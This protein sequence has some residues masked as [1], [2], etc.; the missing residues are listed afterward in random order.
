MPL[1]N[2]L[3]TIKRDKIESADAAHGLSGHI[4]WDGGCTCPGDFAKAY[5]G[6]ADF[7]MSGGLFSGHE[8]SG[9]ELIE[10]DYLYAIKDG[11][12]FQPIYKGKRPDLDETAAVISQLKYKKD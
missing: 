2:N 5:G 4:L 12:L 1:R 3:K 9:G 10:V 8:E 6:G 11:A 7:I